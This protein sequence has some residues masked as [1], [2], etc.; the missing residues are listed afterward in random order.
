MS[1]F[2]AEEKGALSV[3]LI[4][5]TNL[6]IRVPKKDNHTRTADFLSSHGNCT[7][8]HHHYYNKLLSRASRYLGHKRGWVL[9]NQ[10]IISWRPH[11]DLSQ[12]L[13]K[14]MALGQLIKIYQIV[15]RFLKAHTLS[16]FLCRGRQEHIPIVA[17]STKAK[18]GN[19]I[20]GYN[21]TR[22]YNVEMTKEWT[23]PLCSVMETV[24]TVWGLWSQQVWLKGL[25]VLC[26]W[27][28]T[29]NISKLEFALLKNGI[30]MGRRRRV[31]QGWNTALSLG[32]G[33]ELARAVKK[34]QCHEG[35]KSI[36]NTLPMSLG[37]TSDHTLFYHIHGGRKHSPPTHH[38]QRLPPGN[39]VQ[40]VGREQWKEERSFVFFFMYLLGF[41]F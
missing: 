12:E 16:R 38:T 31:G 29:S 7:W 32:G 36:S 15:S 41:Y 28:L 4:T 2:Y 17:L 10:C 11:G 14:K 19:H 13:R 1:P 9:L 34:L 5:E 20:S 18:D 30:T 35:V 3:I 6:S 37:C 23:W 40:G 8:N 21:P 39:A 27:A 33:E 25:P 26:P 24:L 22:S